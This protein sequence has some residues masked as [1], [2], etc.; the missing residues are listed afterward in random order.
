MK[1]CLFFVLVPI[2]A[3]MLAGQNIYVNRPVEGDVWKMGDLETIVWTSP[4][5]TE[6]TFKITLWKGDVN[7]GTIKSGIP[8]TQ[9][10]FMWT[11]GKL[12]N[13]PD[14]NPDD[15]YRVKVRLQ[16]QPFSGFSGSF[17]IAIAFTAVGRIPRRDRIL[18]LSDLEVTGQRVVPKPRFM[19]KE[20]AYIADIRSGGDKTAPAHKARLVIYGPAGFQTR[21]RMID[22]PEIPAGRTIYVSHNYVLPMMGV[23]RNELTLDPGG[24]IPEKDENNNDAKMS[25]TVDPL[26]DL[27]ACVDHGKRPRPGKSVTVH[28][29]VKN[30]GPGR[31]EASLMHTYMDGYP[32]Q[33]HSVPPLD[34]GEI[35][36]IVRSGS[37]SD[38]TQKKIG[39]NCGANPIGNQQITEINTANNN[40]NGYFYLTPHGGPH[41][42]SGLMRCSTSGDR[43][44][45]VSELDQS[46]IVNR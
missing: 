26:P 4:G 24:N 30:I 19:G 13:A 9:N 34:H 41:G 35:F 46:K 36:M 37:W 5:I 43:N 31:S 27:V 21:T 25:Y 33:T 2:M 40:A 7:L 11:V 12:E 10:S 1:K 6:G 39:V 16:E 23:Y 17:E 3:V 32:I 18:P 8:Y 38:F 14:A 22:I 45:R 15:G 28:F 20:M 44:R 29:Y 42:T